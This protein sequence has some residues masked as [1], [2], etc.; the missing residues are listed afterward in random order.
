MSCVKT[1][2][3]A[4]KNGHDNKGSKQRRESIPPAPL[5]GRNKNKILHVKKYRHFAETVDRRRRWYDSSGVLNRTTLFK[6]DELL[7]LAFCR[8]D[9]HIFHPIR[10]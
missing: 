3:N 8:H 4:I 7:A 10:V 6:S 5:I 1:P 2:K 9:Y